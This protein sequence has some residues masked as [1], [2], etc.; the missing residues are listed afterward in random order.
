MT[1]KLKNKLI[2]LV[3]CLALLLS[4]GAVFPKETAYALEIYDGTATKAKVNGIVYWYRSDVDQR[5]EIQI[6]AIQVPKGRKELVLPESIDGKKVVCLHLRKED[7]AKPLTG[8][9]SLYLPSGMT[10]QGNDFNPTCIPPNEDYMGN[11]L[12][13]SLNQY[14]K[15]VEKIQV[16]EDNPYMTVHNGVLF[17]KNISTLLYYPYEK[18]D[19]EYTEPSTQ[20]DALLAGYDGRK[21]LKKLTYSNNKEYTYAASCANTNIETV[22]IPKNVQYL[23]YESFINCTKLKKVEGGKGLVVIHESAFEG[24][25]SLTSIRFSNKLQ[26]I[27]RRAFWGCRRLK[28]IKLPKNLRWMKDYVFYGTACRKVTIPATVTSIG[29]KAFSKRT[30]VKRRTYLKAVNSK[31]VKDKYAKN[32]YSYVAMVTVTDV[33][34]GKKKYYEFEDISEIYSMKR[35]ITIKKRRPYKLEILAELNLGMDQTAEGYLLPSMLRYKSSNPKVA[36]VTKKGVVKARKKGTATI[37]VELRT[38][39]LYEWA[40]DCKVTVKVR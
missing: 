34:S 5:T 2:L 24:C 18:K 37:Y 16:S 22:V 20:K 14:F 13:P 32:H 23:W 8:I 30:K 11:Y 6:T 21:Y 31:Y 25:K 27:E 35:K 40:G 38:Q 39:G 7:G 26:G 19:A 3:V 28:N 9:K 33:D 17:D 15:K 36:K 29:K 10:Y 1:V 12:A 4:T